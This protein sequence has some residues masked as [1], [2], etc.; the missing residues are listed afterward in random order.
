MTPK[1]KAIELRNR[2]LLFNGSYQDE[3]DTTV[4]TYH[5]NKSMA[6]KLALIT[7]DEILSIKFDGNSVS[8]WKNN[9][10][11]WY[12]AEYWRQVKLEIEKL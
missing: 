12:S 1:E 5:I 10:H 3:D 2:H 4:N 11:H 6:K 7:V 9:P 8:E